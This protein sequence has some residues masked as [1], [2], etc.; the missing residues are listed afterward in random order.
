[1]KHIMDVHADRFGWR[2]WHLDE[3]RAR[4]LSP[5]HRGKMRFGAR[6]VESVCQHRQD[7]L[8]LA[9]DCGCGIYFEDLDRAIQ[10][11][12]VETD[13]LGA[14]NVAVT[15]GAAVGDVAPDPWL[16]DQA[17]RSPR[18]A[19]LA[20]LVPPASP[21]AGPLRKRYDVNVFMKK[22]R[23]AALRDVRDA[24][25]ADLR[26]TPASGFFDTLRAEPLYPGD[27]HIMDTHPDM[28]G[29]AVW[30]FHPDRRALSDP[31]SPRLIACRRN[32]AGAVYFEDEKG[33]G[34]YYVSSG[35]YAAD[36]LV[37]IAQAYRAAGWSDG[38]VEF[39]ATFG[40]ADGA[41][42]PEPGTLGSF[43]RSRRHFPSVICIPPGRERL[44]RALE[45]DWGMGVIPAL[46]NQ[47][48]HDI[49]KLMRTKLGHMS[50]TGLD[51]TLTR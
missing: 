29:W 30:R 11:W 47:V 10:R 23:P 22:I 27:E 26:H 39:A 1:M 18:H 20:I 43:Y 6:V 28:F 51:R 13:R 19:I 50:D 35:F 8:A 15:F 3:S 41:I 42:T 45:R 48:F 33:P 44:K 32:R 9:P 17:F 12:R 38:D 49:E 7:P 25:R 36:R 2:V 4:L 24:V 31:E 5:I 16:P 46:S 21:A 40:I 14:E 34:L 37:G